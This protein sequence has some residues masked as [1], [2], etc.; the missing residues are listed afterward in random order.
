METPGR[1]NGSEFEPVEYK[2]D[3]GGSMCK[4]VGKKLDVF[5][6]VSE[7]HFFEDACAL[8][9]TTIIVAE[10]LNMPCS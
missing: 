3:S 6:P 1:E 2:R 4:P 9:D 7:A 5:A 10:Y 8:T